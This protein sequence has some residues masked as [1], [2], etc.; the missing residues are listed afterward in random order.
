V[1]AGYVEAAKANVARFE[2][3]AEELV[4]ELPPRRER[5]DVE[6]AM[7]ADAELGGH[8]ALILEPG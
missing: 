4:L 7:G 5:I 1:R 2:A 6:A 3:S 8:E